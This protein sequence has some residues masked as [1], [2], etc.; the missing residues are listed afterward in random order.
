MDHQVTIMQDKVFPS[1]LSIMIQLH[2]H[3][4][5]LTIILV[6]TTH[7]HQQPPPINR[8][9]CTHPSLPLLLMSSPQVKTLPLHPP[10]T[11]L[12]CPTRTDQLRLRGTTHHPSR[13]RLSQHLWLEETRDPQVLRLILDFITLLS[14]RYP[15]KSLRDSGPCPPIT[16]EV[17]RITRA[18]S[19]DTTSLLHP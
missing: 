12:A 11:S 13:K 10:T 8:Q 1:L 5:S 3:S 18:A 4:R 6:A 19:K 16:R 14:T 15:L 17:P 9:I 7:Q 2:S